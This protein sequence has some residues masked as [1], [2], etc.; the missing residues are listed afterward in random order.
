MGL[1]VAKKLKIYG[2]GQNLLTDAFS[3]SIRGAGPGSAEMEIEE[4]PSEPFLVFM[5]DKT[6]AGSF[7]M[8]L[9]K[10]FAD[11]FT[12]AGLVI[13]DSLH[14]GLRLDLDLTA[15]WAVRHQPST[16]CHVP[17]SMSRVG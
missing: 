8:P 7:N 10:M 14:Q 9:Y 1:D 15:R 2:A 3:R 11:P 13:A 5:G 17:C 12:T 4:R 6:S 16:P